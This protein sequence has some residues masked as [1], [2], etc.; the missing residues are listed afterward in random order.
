MKNTKFT[1][2]KGKNTANQ[3]NNTQ[4][5]CKGSGNPTKLSKVTITAEQATLKA[6]G[7]GEASVRECKNLSVNKETGAL[8]AVRYEGE[9]D[10]QFGTRLATF[11]SDEGRMSLTAS[12][13]SV[14]VVNLDTAE[15]QSVGQL[16]SEA[17]SAVALSSTQLLV[18]TSG[19]TCRVINQS[20]K[21]AILEDMT[22]PP[23]ISLEVTDTTVYTAQIPEGTLT[24]SYPHGTGLLA[25]TDAEALRGDLLATYNSLALQANDDGYLTQPV[26]A[27]VRLLDKNYGVVFTGPTVLLGEF[28]LTDALEITANV[29]AGTRSATA[30]QTSAFRI[31]LRFPQALPEGWE[32]RVWGIEVQTSMPLHT[33]DFSA[34]LRG[35][36]LA[37]STGTNSTITCAMPGVALDK[38]GELQRQS[39]V[40]Q[41]LSHIDS[42]MST[43]MVMTLNAEVAGRVYD[44]DI[45]TLYPQMERT[46][47]LKVLAQAVTPVAGYTAAV[48]RD[49]SEPHRF[50]ASA[51]ALNGD[52]LLVANPTPVR[53]EGYPLTAMAVSRGSGSWHAYA[54]VAFSDGQEKV[55]WSSQGSDQAPL[56]LSPVLS[57]PSPDAAKMTIAIATSDGTILKTTVDLTP[58]DAARSSYY[59]HP[60]LAPWLPTTTASV[61]L[62]PAEKRVATCHEG[63]VINTVASLPLTPLSALLAAPCAISTV[64]PAARSASSWDFGKSHFY[65]FSR[66]G[67]TAVGVGTSRLL[68]GANRISMYPVSTPAQ[69]V[70]TDTA[71]YVLSDRGTL[72]AVSGNRSTLI[73]GTGILDANDANGRLSGLAERPWSALTTL[74]IEGEGTTLLSPSTLSYTQVTEDDGS[75]TVP[76]AW[77]ARVPLSAPIRAACFDLAASLFTGSVTISLDNGQEPDGSLLVLRLDID[78]Q[79]N[80][81]LCYPVTAP[82][83]GW[84][85]VRVEGRVSTDFLFRKIQLIY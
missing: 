68:S 53:Y 52:T 37:D 28:Q 35:N 39:I 15:Y 51:C 74:V 77:E 76:I 14:Y 70:W 49:C 34:A 9:R 57:Y 45:S 54:H 85:T 62:I 61:Y 83:R 82:W 18:F 38:G 67:V 16:P 72:F 8:A 1:D 64:T 75:D 44:I 59:I 46:Q 47:L 32:D 33:V 6:P 17:L 12:G 11:A 5:Q 58:D 56:A 23:A 4:K 50:T 73:A 29:T 30:V 43:R 19:G 81:P 42:L 7:S 25:K 63:V 78:G 48:A 69:V 55:V 22:Q 71:V 20:G 13:L 60:S 40:R 21:W 41:A 65:A 31:G 36:V 2:Q 27:R 26:L 66:F 80:A 79:V 24:G 84:A 3:G 10:A